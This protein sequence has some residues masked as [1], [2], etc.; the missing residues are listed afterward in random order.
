MRSSLFPC[1]CR[2]EPIPAVL[3]VNKVD[4]LISELQLIEITHRLTGGVVDG[5]PIGTESIIR[6]TNQRAGWL[7]DAINDFSWN[8]KL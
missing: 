4:R 6:G 2:Y 1:C 7:K 3:V 8:E 5:V